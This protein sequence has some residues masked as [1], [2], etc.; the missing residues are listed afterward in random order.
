MKKRSIVSLVLCLMMLLST[1]AVRAEETTEYSLT[2]GN[3][4]RILG[5][6]EMRDEDTRTFNWPAA[7]FEFEFSGKKAEVLVDEL[8]NSGDAE[9]NG[10]F[11]NMAVYSGDELVRRERIRLSEGW[12]TIYTAVEGDPEEKTIQFIRSSEPWM[13]TA[14]FSK[15]R[16]DEAPK[17]TEEKA[18]LIEFIGDSITAGYANAEELSENTEYCAENTDNWVSY[19][20]IVARNF[21]A[22]YNVLAYS[23]KGVYANRSMSSIEGNMTEEFGYEEVLH[24]S[25]AL[26]MST[27][28]LHNFAEYQPQVVFILL[29]EN[30]N[31]APVPEETFKT[32]YD[33]LLNKVRDSYPD[34]TIICASMS[35]NIKYVRYYDIIKELV[36]ADNR[37]EA[38]KFYMLTFDEYR[39]VNEWHPD[40]AEHERMAAK[41]IEKIDSIENIWNSP[42]KNSIIKVELDGTPI[43]FDVQPTLINDTTMLPIRA[44]ADSLGAN[45]TWNGEDGSIILEKDGKTA[46][47][48]IGNEKLFK[49]DETI[50]LTTPPTIVSGRTLVPLRA[51]AESFDIDVEWNG[52]EKLV[53]LTTAE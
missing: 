38:N 44:V 3:Y 9:Y 48:Q 26:N 46:V 21:N 51:V 22:D 35:M 43:A 39:S 24:T 53:S 41:L 14:S 13:G 4:V 40:G 17:A 37:G 8:I 10:S 36:E 1:V 52:E 34:A 47:L 11:F 18:R 16:T 42:R 19:A 50:E 49:G 25:S 27:K 30:D 33:N 32:A 6:G 20:G 7:G 15:L 45:L 2:E 5:R 28:K 29:G 12:N 31:A 23:G